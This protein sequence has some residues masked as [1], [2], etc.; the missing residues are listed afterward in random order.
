VLKIIAIKKL[1]CGVK[2]TGN[3]KKDFQSLADW[4]TYCKD[5]E[6]FDEL[7]IGTRKAEKP[8]D[9]LKLAEKFG[10]EKVSL[11]CMQDF[12]KAVLSGEIK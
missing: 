9:L 8:E 2:I 1:P 3:I 4:F 11:V 12:L 6:D 7:L 5:E 10:S